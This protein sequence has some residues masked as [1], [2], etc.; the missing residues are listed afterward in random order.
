MQTAHVQTCSTHGDVHSTCICA[1]HT[2][3]QHI[4]QMQT[5]TAHAQTH[6]AQTCSTYADMQQLCTVHT[7]MCSTCADSWIAPLGLM[8]PEEELQLSHPP[9]PPTPCTPR[10]SHLGSHQFLAGR[11]GSPRRCRCPGDS[12]RLCSRWSGQHL[13]L[14]SLLERIVSHVFFLKQ[15]KVIA[16]P[17]YC[18]NVI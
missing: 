17:I 5:C 4:Q 15:K 13:P 9:V 2:H 18:S 10:P 12:L 7:D 11:A 8:L 14:L 16:V 1:V 6:E 3:A